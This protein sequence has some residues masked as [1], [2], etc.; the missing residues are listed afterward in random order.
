MEIEGA[1]INDGRLLYVKVVNRSILLV[2]ISTL[3]ILQSCSLKSNGIDYSHCVC[4]WPS[5]K[6]K[7]MDVSL[8]TPYMRLEVI[9]IWGEKG[10]IKRPNWCGL[11]VLFWEWRADIELRGV[12]RVAE[13]CYSESW[14]EQH[15]W[16]QGVLTHFFFTNP[17]QFHFSTV[18]LN[19][20]LAL[21][22]FHPTWQILFYRR[23]I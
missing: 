23:I 6:E 5:G 10:A 19:N 20:I 15:S 3:S 4:V 9:C 21:Y 11:G 16:H 2:S 13:S 17:Q 14:C 7:K 18:T 22:R 1:R 8:W 12:E